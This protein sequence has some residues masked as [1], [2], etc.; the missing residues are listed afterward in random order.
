MLRRHCSARVIATALAATC[1]FWT[2]TVRAQ[3]SPATRDSLAQYLDGLAAFGF[4]GQIVVAEG[5]SILIESA[6]GVADADGHRIGPQTRFALGSITKSVTGALIT[7]QAEQGVLKLDDTLGRWFKVVPADKRRITLRML[8][9][10]TSGLPMD[11]ESVHEDD[12]PQMVLAKTLAEPLVAAPGERFIYSNAGYQLLAAVLEAATGRS[13]VELAREQLLLPSGMRDSGTGA[14]FGASVRDGATGRNE[15]TMSGSTRDWRQKWAGTGAGDLVSTARDLHRWARTLQ[16]AGPLSIAALD[17]MMTRRQPLARGMSYG[18]GVYLVP[19]SEGPDRVSIGGDVPGYHAAAWFMRRA[20]RR[21]TSVVMSGEIHGRSLPVR[22]IQQ[23]LW[24]MLDGQPVALPPATVT[25]PRDRLLA[26]AGAW[27]VGDGGELR[28]ERD[29]DALRLALAGPDA[30]ALRYGSDSLGMRSALDTRAVS[31]LRAA[32]AP[33]EGAL[34]AE[35]QEV[36]QKFWLEPLRRGMRQRLERFG[37]LE[38]VT[39]SGTIAL[40]WLAQGSRSY[41]DLRFARGASRVSIA[42]LEGG[43]LDIAFEEE[44]PAPVL[45]PVAPFAEGGLIAWD[46]LSGDTIRLEPFMDAK[47]AGLRVSGQGLQAIARRAVTKSSRS[48]RPNR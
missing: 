27:D 13:Y 42:W 15:W 3:L 1:L 6:S 36:E 31:V 29:G 40:P 46:L 39:P 14:R 47:G 37:A 11:A 30:M 25:W 48:G 19:E 41:L 22:V 43:L 21:I 17:T 8:L 24:R 20:P 9:T 26:L 35:L 4:A 32:A 33:D 38:D 23:S 5:D 12:T 7:L 16:G 45:L 2:T 44:R 28:L 34:R 18:F 10:H